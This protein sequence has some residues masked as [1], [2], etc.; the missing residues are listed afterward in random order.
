MVWNTT[1]E[2]LKVKT[3]SLSRTETTLDFDDVERFNVKHWGIVVQRLL[4]TSVQ[5][6]TR[7]KVAIGGSKLK[8]IK[9]EMEGL[10]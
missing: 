3:L 2:S 9:E 6:M 5:E 8:V 10:K 7:T 1:C 4:T